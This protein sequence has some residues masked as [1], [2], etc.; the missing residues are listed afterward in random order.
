MQQVP[1]WLQKQDSPATLQG[2]QSQRDPDRNLEY[3]Q[4]QIHQQLHHQGEGVVE[5]K[6]ELG[7]YE[8]TDS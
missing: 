2:I 8:D 3:P 6:E 5:G 1:T 7:Q 4:L